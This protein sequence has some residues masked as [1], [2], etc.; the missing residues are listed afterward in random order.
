MQELSCKD[1]LKMAAAALYSVV[2]VFDGGEHFMQ[3]L[4]RR[5]TRTN[6]LKVTA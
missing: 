6:T 4:L 5:R 2:Q 3:R 1:V